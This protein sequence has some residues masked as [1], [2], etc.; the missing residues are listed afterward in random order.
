[1]IYFH[2][3]NQDINKRII[4]EIKDR[5]SFRLEKDVIIIETINGKY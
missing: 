3:Y 1:M 4:C 2:Q 5:L